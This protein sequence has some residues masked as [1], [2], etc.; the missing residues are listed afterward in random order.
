[1]TAARVAVQIREVRSLVAAAKRDGRRVG[2]VPTMGA[3][4]E[5]HARLIETARRECG[6]VVVSIFVNP[7]QFA[8]GED[9]ARYPRSFDAD[10]E[11]CRRC[12]ADWIFAPET[13]AI[14][15]PG[16][17]AQVEVPEL[18]DLLCGA[19]RKGHFRGVCTVVA[20]LLHIVEP[21]VAYFGQKDAQ[22][23]L[24]IRRMVA[25]LDMP[26]EI[27]AVETVREADGLA[28][29]SRNVYLDPGERRLAPALFRSLENGRK[30]IAAGERI[31]GR[32]ETAIRA[33][34]AAVSGLRIDYVAVVNADT[35]MPPASLSGPTLIAAAVFFGKTRLIDNIQL[36]IP[37][38]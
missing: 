22:Q 14:Y 35:L 34:L 30:L 26:I 1:M 10:R 2:L 9:F 11:L 15:P 7:A 23:L 38:A 32:I 27:R 33:E 31:P 13:A 29:S 4:H 6:L 20:K 16:F 36:D 18:Q 19:S 37:S 3:L 8:P 17:R 21:D 24:L 28:L 5:G 12:G 25:D